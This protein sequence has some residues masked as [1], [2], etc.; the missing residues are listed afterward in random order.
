MR[1]ILYILVM[2]VGAV[3]AAWWLQHL[4]GNVTLQRGEWTVQAP[5]SLTIVA[6]I[7]LLLVFYFGGSNG[8]FS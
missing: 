2:S 7:L 8:P 6:L 5:L 1:R 3:A 4:G